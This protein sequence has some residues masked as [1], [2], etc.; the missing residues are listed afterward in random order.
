VRALHLAVRM[1][2]AARKLW[3]RI[4]NGAQFEKLARLYSVSPDRERGGDLGF[5]TRGQKPKAFEEACFRLK[6]GQLSPVTPSEY[7]YHLFKVLERRP[8]RPRTFEEAR[9]DIV[10]ALRREK[11]AAAEEA[12][13][14]ELRARAAIEIDARAVQKVK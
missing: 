4:H 13:R 3:E 6:P 14:R 1:E 9:A 8:A 5:F 7:G 10:A 11:E 2:P 12:F